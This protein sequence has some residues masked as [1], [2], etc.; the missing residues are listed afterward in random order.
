M[1]LADWVALILFV[2]LFPFFAVT[3][4]KEWQQLKGTWE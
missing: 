3:G 4:C 1:S 2:L